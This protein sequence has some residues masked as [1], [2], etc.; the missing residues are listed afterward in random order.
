MDVFFKPEVLFFFFFTFLILWGNSFKIYVNNYFI[1]M[2][3]PLNR[4]IHFVI[5]WQIYAAIIIQTIF[6]FFAFTG[7]NIFSLLYSKKGNSPDFLLLLFN[8]KFTLITW[9]YFVPLKFKQ[10]SPLILLR[11]FLHINNKFVWQS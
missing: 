7:R 3:Q 10:N 8:N 4:L 2:Y 9:D 6:K 5:W 11:F 1:I